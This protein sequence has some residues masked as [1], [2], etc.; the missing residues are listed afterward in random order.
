MF[1]NVG[2]RQYFKA[3]LDF[4]RVSQRYFHVTK[5]TFEMELVSSK[6]FKVSSE[7]LEVEES[8]VNREIFIAERS[9]TTSS[10]PVA[11]GCN[12]VDRKDSERVR[13]REHLYALTLRHIERCDERMTSAELER[14]IVEAVATC[15][16]MRDAARGAGGMWSYRLGRLVF[17]A[18]K[19]LTFEEA[20]REAALAESKVL[21]PDKLDRCL[22][23]YTA[24]KAIRDR[25]EAIEHEQ[26]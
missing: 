14:S 23:T 24:W 19:S 22:T 11:P 13:L 7:V 1:E 10:D 4:L 16:E 5:E 15:P 25:C 21:V 2:K 8:K 3:M 18:G 6:V 20:T 12:V 26:R 9:A 17:V